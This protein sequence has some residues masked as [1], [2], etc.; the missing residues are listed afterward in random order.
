MCST[1]PGPGSFFRHDE[2]LELCLAEV[3]AYEK[4]ITDESGR[5]RAQAPGP[6][7]GVM[8][9]VD[10]ADFETGCGFDGICTVI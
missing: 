3:W 6:V 8:R 2:V 7:G 5:Q 1:V 4:G 10:E 9:A